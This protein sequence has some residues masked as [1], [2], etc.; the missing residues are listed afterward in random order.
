MRL[1]HR[2]RYQTANLR[3]C[4]NVDHSIFSSLYCSNTCEDNTILQRLC[5][6]NVSRKRLGPL[7]LPQSPI[8][9]ILTRASHC[10]DQVV[11]VNQRAFTRHQLVCEDRGYC[12]FACAGE[13]IDPDKRRRLDL[14]ITG[15]NRRCHCELYVVS[16]SLIC[17]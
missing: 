3:N 5:C 7:L 14:I 2:S 17:C 9:R 11:V 16:S 8:F 1:Q 4:Q 10:I 13:S 12:V 15:Q 6:K